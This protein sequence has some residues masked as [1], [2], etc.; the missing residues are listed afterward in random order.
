MVEIRRKFI[1]QVFDSCQSCC[2]LLIFF[3]PH[4]G[5]A[6]YGNLTLLNLTEY[7]FN[8]QVRDR[9]CITGPAM[10]MVLVKLRN[11]MDMNGVWPGSERFLNSFLSCDWIETGSEQTLFIRHVLACRWFGNLRPRSQ[12]SSCRFQNIL[13]AITYVG[14]DERLQ[15]SIHY[16]FN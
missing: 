3:R 13:L 11:Q 7:L 15:N 14:N 16:C 4:F 5:W 6:I 12:K 9:W 8:G 2:R 1:V 10:I